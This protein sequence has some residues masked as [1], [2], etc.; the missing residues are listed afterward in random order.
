MKLAFLWQILEKKSLNIKFYQNPSSGSRVVAYGQK[1]MTKLIVTFHNFVNTPKN[2]PF[3]LI[4]SS[5]NAL[6]QF[7]LWSIYS[8][9]VFNVILLI[10]ILIFLGSQN[11]IVMTIIWYQ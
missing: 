2:Q 9:A 8:K 1:D 4:A 11:F 7:S 6:C 10:A 5:V 3:G